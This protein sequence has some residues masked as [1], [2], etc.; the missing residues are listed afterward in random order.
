MQKL[1]SKAE[2]EKRQYNILL[3]A[4]NTMTDILKSESVMSSFDGMDKENSTTPGP[5]SLS[6]PNGGATT[7]TK[8]RCTMYF[9]RHNGLI[10]LASKFKELPPS[11]LGPTFTLFQTLIEDVCAVNRE[12]A[13]DQDCIL[14]ITAFLQSMISFTII[15]HSSEKQFCEVLFGMAGLMKMHRGLLVEWF[16]V[17]ERVGGAPS[18]LAAEPVNG[19]SN[20]SIEEQVLDNG[21]HREFPLFCLLLN[22]VYHGNKVGEYSRTGLLYLIEVASESEELV[23]WV[24]RSDL[25]SLMAS[26]L[27]ALYSQ[28][29]RGINRSEILQEASIETKD[30]Q[31][32]LSYLLFWQD[33]LVFA[34]KSSSLTK[35]LVYH[36]D[37]LFVRQLLYPSI[38]EN[39]DSTGGYSDLLISVL[40]SILA[41][42]D[43]NLL[44]QA[45]V[46]YFIGRPVSHEHYKSSTNLRIPSVRLFNSKEGAPILTMN[47]ILCSSLLSVK[48][49]Q[50]YHALRLLC[51]L[52]EKYYPY[53]MDTLINVKRPLQNTSKESLLNLTLVQN[54][55]VRALRDRLTE[56]AIQRKVCA[57]KI[58]IEIM[59][60][61]NPFPA[62]SLKK[63]FGAE[64]L[65][66][67][68]M[69]SLLL[70]L[71]YP[72]SRLRLHTLEELDLAKVDKESLFSIILGERV[73]AFWRNSTQENVILTQCLVGL[74]TCGWISFQ[75]WVTT[76]VLTLIRDLSEEYALIRTKIPEFDS[77]LQ[78]LKEATGAD[79]VTHVPNTREIT[80][81]ST[82]NDN[83]TNPVE[84]ASFDLRYESF[85]SLDDDSQRS[86]S[87][88]WTSPR[89]ASELVSRSLSIFR[90]PSVRSVRG[91][92]SEKYGTET[93]DAIESDDHPGQENA[94]P[95]GDANVLPRSSLDQYAETPF[96]GDA[97]NASESLEA[98]EVQGDGSGASIHARLETGVVDIA[99]IQTKVKQVCLNALIF[100]EFVCEIKALFHV[101]YW[102]FES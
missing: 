102:L 3:A 39:T 93:E 60:E 65:E 97:S 11:M 78:E 2:S 89:R 7:P 24:L 46:C 100:E 17:I 51:I 29:S 25:G 41:T 61:Q 68:E 83:K 88:G 23:M 1:L 94:A 40:T 86:A 42:L 31:T 72:Q 84:D 99:G 87:L 71:S 14:G 101:R 27:C 79:D 10:T 4:V 5:P 70:K 8:L 53:L 15:E 57:Y 6:D 48:T 12:V 26:G 90:L 37:V 28:L 52:L 35:N 80:P 91:L 82:E 44:S 55:C 77:L 32:F 75:G 67:A 36:F 98:A 50:R 47:D 22:Y 62:P 96:R 45:I 30:L 13:A 54:V 92:F 59:A 19:S 21:Y 20:R 95:D 76:T 16:A 69:A 63:R 49:K 85:Q 56:R 74:G 81:L 43:H 64:E 34:K 33:M 9:L 58:D 66:R 73:P 38:V 18:R